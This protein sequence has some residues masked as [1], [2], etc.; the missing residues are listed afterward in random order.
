[1]TAETGSS[2]QAIAFG[3]PDRR[4]FAIYHPGANANAA[5]PAV[6]LC[7]AFG[8]EAIR[9]HRLMRVLAERLARQGYPVLRFDYFG[10]GDSMGE[11]LDGD[12]DGW[13]GD[14]LLADAEVRARSG[15]DSTVWLGIRLGAAVALRAARQAPPGLQRLVLFDMVIDGPA[16]LAHLRERHV[17]C[18]EAAYSLMPNP[19]PSEQ[20][21]DPAQFRDEAI[22]FALSP[23]L[24]RQITALDVTTH[25]WPA[26][27]A[28]IIALSDPEGADGRDLAAAMLRQ[29]GRV[30][31]VAV[32]HGTD[33]TRDTADNTALVP[34]Q[35]L[36]A[37]VQQVGATA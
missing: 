14:V 29:P 9:A 11:D 28:S 23:T 12:L 3:P 13:A 4:L 34:T 24:R 19:T 36:L 25:R 21:L 7:N 26:Q 1:M 27:P 17:A 6:V 20:A 22:G 37:L 15:G 18:L 35:A 16:Y 5:G 10:T 32:Q 30:H 33:W 8:Q 2:L 31:V